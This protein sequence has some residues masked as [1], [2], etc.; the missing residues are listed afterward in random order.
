MSECVVDINTDLTAHVDDASIQ[1]EQARSAILERVVKR[2]DSECRLDSG[3]FSDHA[4]YSA[5][6]EFTQAT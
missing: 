2:L 6:H 1:E 5:H 4:D 3:A